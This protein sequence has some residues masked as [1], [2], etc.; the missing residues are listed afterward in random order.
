[1]S[2]STISTGSKSSFEVLDAP[3]KLKCIIKRIDLLIAKK[4]VYY[5]ESPIHYKCYAQAF[6][7]YQAEKLFWIFDNNGIP[8]KKKH[9]ES[10]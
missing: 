3:K 4:K 10:S 2:L 8:F 5:V 6:G 9:Q 1:M 7:V